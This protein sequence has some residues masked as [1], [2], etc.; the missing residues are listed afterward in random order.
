MT[1]GDGIDWNAEAR[2]AAAAGMP[3]E[4]PTELTERI[5]KVLKAREGYALYTGAKV[6]DCG[7]NIARFYPAAKLAGFEYIGV[8][9]AAE[10]LVIARDRYPGI[11]LEQSML[12]GDW[13]KKVGAVDAAFCNAVLQHNTLD[14]KRA[15]LKQI[16]YAVQ[17]G[18]VFAMQESTV[19]VE[20]K[21][22]LQQGRWIEL[23]EAFGF[24]LHSMWH[25][26]A[27]YGI[28]DG[29]VFVRVSR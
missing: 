9:Q 11:H 4:S 5:A 2:R 21:T 24:K 28:L 25:P 15:I 14:E 17:P 1:F 7:C 3:G 10:A 18:G 12:W 8:D 19:I 13:P 27:E 16:S 26:N 29:Y 22:Q 23:V 20:T 6:V